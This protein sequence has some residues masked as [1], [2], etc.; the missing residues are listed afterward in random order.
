MESYIYQSV[1]GGLIGVI[2]AKFFLFLQVC[3]ERRKFKKRL[4]QLM[5]A[6]ELKAKQ[7]MKLNI[8]MAGTLIIYSITFK[9]KIAKEI[10]EKK[11][12]KINN[13]QS[14]NNEKI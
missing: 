5:K 12:N 6:I 7:D 1:I 2:F 11:T 10:I 9:K 4:P 8:M 14:K 13:A 3:N